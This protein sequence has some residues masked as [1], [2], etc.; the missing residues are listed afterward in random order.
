MAELKRGYVSSP[1]FGNLF[2]YV[3]RKILS[4]SKVKAVR[5]KAML[6]RNY[7]NKLPKRVAFTFTKCNN[8]ACH[9]TPVM[10]LPDRSNDALTLHPKVRCD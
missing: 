4:W 7:E 1:I 8:N 6:H 5:M 3:P 9:A 10:S 2:S